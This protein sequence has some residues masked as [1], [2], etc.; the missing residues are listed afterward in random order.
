MTSLNEKGW[1]LTPGRGT[2]YKFQRK[3]LKNQ[4]GNFC[5]DISAIIEDGIH[6]K[7]EEN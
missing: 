1:H 6:F 5:F 3:K 7:Q 4:S 2:V